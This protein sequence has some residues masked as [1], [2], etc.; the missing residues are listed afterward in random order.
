MKLFLPKIIS[1]LDYATIK[2]GT[3]QLNLIDNASSSFVRFIIPHLSKTENIIC[4][5]GTGNNGVD[6]LYIALKLSSRG[7]QVRVLCIEGT[8]RPT[9]L[10]KEAKSTVL[11]S[12]ISL[13][14]YDSKQQV[15]EIQYDDVII[16]GIFGNGLN[17]PL[18]DYYVQIFMAI[19]RLNKPIFAIDIPSGMRA[20]GELMNVILKCKATLAFQFPKLVFFQREASEFLGEWEC[21]EIGISSNLIKNQASDRFLI[22]PQLIRSIIRT[23]NPHSHKGSYGHSLMIGGVI[24]M[25]GAVTLS[26]KASLKIGAGKCTIMSY[27]EN[28]EICQAGLP[29]A[30]FKH[31]ERVMNDLNRQTVGIGPGLGKSKTAKEVLRSVIITANKPIVFDADALNL[32]SEDPILLAAIPKHSILTPHTGEFHSLFGTCTTDFQRFT[33]QKQE[34]IARDIFIILKGK[35]TTIACPN[36][37][38]YFNLTGNPGMAT[39]GSGDVLT[40]VITGLLAQHYTSIEAAILGVYIHGLSGDIA[41]ESQGAMSLMASDI[42]SKIPHA[43]DI[44]KRNNQ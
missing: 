29:E 28:R 18:S 23:R 30:S 21:T 1:Q 7:Y 39:G 27:A 16:D 26:A 38:F 10:Y 13:E 33:I 15:E 9:S 44:I 3:S 41:E 19:N 35:Y 11:K 14:I 6:G 31:M 22:D 12:K 4:I 8:S 5:C 42:I 20:E 24:G 43:I 40:G 37:L 2:M 17:R 32:L 25:A 36:G 34:A